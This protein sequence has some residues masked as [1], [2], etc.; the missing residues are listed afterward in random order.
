MDKFVAKEIGARIREVRKEEGLS[1][2]SFGQRV[3]VSLPTVTRVETGQ[4]FP[5]AELLLAIRQA[6]GSDLNWLLA[7]EK[8][9]DPLAVAV[10]LLS[11]LS[12]DLN[13]LA[14]AKAGNLYLTGFPPESVAFRCEDDGYA[15]RII[16]GDTVVF[17][18]GICKEGNLVVVCDSW[19]NGVVRQRQLRGGETVYVATDR[20][21]YPPLTDDQVTC[22]G[23]VCGII[24][25]WE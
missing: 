15:P 20:S 1:Q 10:P 3:N 13:G 25:K 2:R 22:L 12:R 21:A 19:G 8:L 11:R 9:S 24:R 18:P 16:S 4:R 17:V 23:R 6:F 14:E 7:G 5:D